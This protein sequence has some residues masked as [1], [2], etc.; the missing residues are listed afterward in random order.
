LNPSQRARDSAHVQGRRL[1]S[2]GIDDYELRSSGLGVRKD[3]T[4]LARPQHAAL[5]A[6]LRQADVKAAI[7]VALPK[8]LTVMNVIPLHHEEASESLAGEVYG[9]RAFMG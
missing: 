3:V 6:A 7:A 1:I 9:H 4:T 8:L 2:T 5:E